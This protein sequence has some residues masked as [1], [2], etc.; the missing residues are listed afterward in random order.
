MRR[1]NEQRNAELIRVLSQDVSGMVLSMAFKVVT[2][3]G[4]K[5]HVHSLN[6][7]RR[8][9]LVEHDMLRINVEVTAGIVRKAWVG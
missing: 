5:L 6:G 9:R 2:S 1:P 4:F 7:E 8:S 3:N